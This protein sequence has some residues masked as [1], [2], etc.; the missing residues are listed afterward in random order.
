MMDT[1]EIAPGQWLEVFEREYLASFIR[2]G[3]AAVKVLIVAPDVSSGVVSHLRD[4]AMRNGFLSAHIDQAVQRV[5]H[6]ERLFGEVARQIDWRGLASDCMRQLLG[7]HG[8]ALPDG[9]PLIDEVAA[10]NA[11]DAGQVRITVEQVVSNSV[12]R[13]Y[14]MARDFR[15]AMGQLCRS[16][17][18]QDEMLCET[19]QRVVEWLRGD[20][21]TIRALRSA[22]LFER[23]NRYMARSMLASLGHWARTAERAGLLLTVDVSRF[24]SG[25]STLAPD[26]TEMRAPT[27]A[28]VMDT[29]EMMRQC[30]DGTDEMGGIAVCFL[31]GPEFVQ[32]EKRGMRAYAALEQRLTDDVRDRRRGNPHAPMVRLAAEWD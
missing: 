13:D 31:A 25:R 26:G 22:M 28:A 10:I 32:D 29:Y 4:A 30:I 21:R 24:A 12:L 18:E 3:G 14:A 19:E 2:Q 11:I 17:V 8:Y 23:I 5:Y 15:V 16:V 9:D 27:P 1:L 7:S 20:L 6:M